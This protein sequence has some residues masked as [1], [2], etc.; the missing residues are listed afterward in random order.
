M[1]IKTRKFNGKIFKLGK[2]TSNKA[3]ANNYARK[4]KANGNNYIRQTFDKDINRKANFYN[5]WYRVK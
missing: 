2:S 4:L 3:I 5:V 1:K